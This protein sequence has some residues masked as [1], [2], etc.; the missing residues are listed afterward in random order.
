MSYNE[1]EILQT[2][3][4]TNGAFVSNGKVGYTVGCESVGVHKSML[5]VQFGLDKN[6]TYTTN[7]IPAFDPTHVNFFNANG[8]ANIV[9][10]DQTLDMYSG[11]CRTRFKVSNVATGDAFDVNCEIMAVKHMPYCTMQTITIKPHQT[12]KVLDLYHI[13]MA[14]QN[15]SQIDY[16]NNIIHNERIN[17]DVGT[18]MLHGKGKAGEKAISICST[19]VFEN[20]SV[21][22]HV[23][24]NKSSTNPNV[25]YQKMQMRDLGMF[26]DYTFHIVSSQMSD[27]DTTIPCE[28]TKNILLTVGR[29]VLKI[30]Q[31]HVKAWM[32]TWK[33]NI[34][35]ESRQDANPADRA[36]V[37]TLMKCVRY[38]LYMVWSSVRDGIN[39]EMNPLLD[40]TGKVFWDG[41]LWFVPLLVFFRP[42]IARNILE[43]RYSMLDTAMKIASSYGFEG[44][45]FPSNHEVVGTGI[46][47]YWDTKGVM[48][49]FNTALVSV[50]VWNYYRVT[51]DKNWLVNKGYNML[52]SNAD[53][54][55]SRIETDENGECHLRDVVGIGN[56][57]ADNPA[58]TNYLVKLCLQCAI[59]ASYELQYIINPEWEVC[60]HNMNIDYI[61]I[62]GEDKVLIKT[63][64]SCTR[65]TRFEFMEHLV[66]LIPLYSETLMRSF[67]PRNI[68]EKNLEHAKAQKTHNNAFND[69]ME[70]WLY[71]ATYTNTDAFEACVERTIQVYTNE[72]GAFDDMC[73][74]AMFLVMLATT[75]GTLRVGGNVTATRFYTERMGLKCMPTSFMPKAWRGVKLSGV[76]PQKNVHMVSNETIVS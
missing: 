50:N 58:L 61:D 16:N 62:F 17:D 39:V 5:S 37:N 6:G 30:R 26:V 70:A 31:G 48:H 8:Q 21:F 40:C 72:W 67:P 36:K 51:L 4:T 9:F 10:K 19:Y 38:N 18:Y 68:I 44:S 32:A 20:D 13:I 22:R 3:K 64:D 69:I 29:N 7:V 15:L 2:E 24:F 71:G 76:G 53:F 55:V 27:A 28:E 12:T 46:N 25:C 33:H 74:S 66:P 35:I 14:G 73:T 42:A 34:G 56:I 63:D 57:Q 49:V 11:I 59:E 41:D 54:F 43:S 75:V 1:W 47:P 23:G 52:K 60:F 65:F 45:K